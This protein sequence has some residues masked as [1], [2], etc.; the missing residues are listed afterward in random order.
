MHACAHACA[1]RYV[2]V[3]GNH[4]VDPVVTASAASGTP[5]GVLAATLTGPDYHPSPAWVPLNMQ[6]GARMH[7]GPFAEELATFAAM[8]QGLLRLHAAPQ[9]P[10]S[11]ACERACVPALL[12]MPTARPCSQRRSLPL[13]CS[14]VNVSHM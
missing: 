13:A 7:L 3:M 9:P 8:E 12:P 5:S 2:S 10:R 6:L 14:L 11:S 4:I 1:R